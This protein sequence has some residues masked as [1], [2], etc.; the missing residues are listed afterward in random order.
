MLMRDDALVN[1]TSLEQLP[2]T[3]EEVAV[4]PVGTGA[5][6]HQADFSCSTSLLGRPSS[7]AR[8]RFR[9]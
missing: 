7:S 6:N 5:S 2:E 1:E 8:A 4:A 9:G 3:V